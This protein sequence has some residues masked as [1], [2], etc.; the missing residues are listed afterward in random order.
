MLK[1]IR[2]R[3]PLIGAICLLLLTLFNY[4]LENDVWRNCIS[5]GLFLF[6]LFLYLISRE[7]KE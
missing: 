5:I 4:F 7:R 2:N 3:L 6:V 1:M